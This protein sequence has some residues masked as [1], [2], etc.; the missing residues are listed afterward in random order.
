MKRINSDEYLNSAEYDALQKERMAE[1]DN[2]TKPCT[3]RLFGIDTL[4]HIDGEKVSIIIENALSPYEGQRIE[5]EINI[6]VID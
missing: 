3:I 4:A 6:R 2:T 1:A 5:V